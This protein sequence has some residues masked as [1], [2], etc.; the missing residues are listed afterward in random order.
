MNLAILF[1]PDGQISAQGAG[2]FNY[3]DD[4]EEDLGA[5]AV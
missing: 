5:G 2:S 1:W 3:L 4:V